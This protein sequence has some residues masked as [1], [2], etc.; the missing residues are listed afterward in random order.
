MSPPAKEKDIEIKF[1]LVLVE[2]CH[3]QIGDLG[4]QRMEGW[5]A[6]CAAFSSF[7]VI[8]AGAVRVRRRHRPRFQP[9]FLV[10]LTLLSTTLPKEQYHN[11][12]R[13]HPKDEL[14]TFPCLLYRLL[15]CTLLPLVP[16]LPRKLRE[17]WSCSLHIFVQD[18][19][20]SIGRH[21]QARRTVRGLPHTGNPPPAWPA[22]HGTW[23]TPRSNLSK[24]LAVRV[25]DHQKSTIHVGT[26]NLNNRCFDWTGPS[27]GGFFS[28]KIEDKQV[29]SRYKYMINPI[30]QIPRE[31]LY[32]GP[33]ERAM[34]ECP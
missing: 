5:R 20:N 6:A 28:P 16:S 4:H 32:L 25:I 15:I 18:L 21:K 23:R 1:R 17:D 24:C 12:Y 26:W 3:L 34:S 30:D 22:K 10:R 29:G 33:L 7:P 9:H 27:F 2:N 31:I 14:C 11:L 8:C 19:C 13:N